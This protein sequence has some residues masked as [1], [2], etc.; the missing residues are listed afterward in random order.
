MRVCVCV[1]VVVCVLVCTLL[2][3]LALQVDGA[4]IALRSLRIG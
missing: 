3:Q 1:C 2:T 4:L